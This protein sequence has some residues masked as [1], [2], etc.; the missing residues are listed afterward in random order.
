MHDNEK[1]SMEV[2]KKLETSFSE[3]YNMK[4]CNDIQLLDNNEKETHALKEWCIAYG[5]VYCPIS[6]TSYRYYFAVEQYNAD[7]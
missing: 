1:E 5:E 3:L 7:I 2:A 4:S 6:G